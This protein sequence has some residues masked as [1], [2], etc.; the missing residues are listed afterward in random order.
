VVGYAPDG[1]EVGRIELPTSRVTSAGFGGVGGRDLYITSA[2]GNETTAEED[3][4]AG[5]LF[6]LHMDIAG[7]PE[8]RSRVGL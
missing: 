5:G 1:R 7:R 4:A 8:F 6:H 3:P 2:G